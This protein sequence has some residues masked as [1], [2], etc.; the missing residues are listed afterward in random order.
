[1]GSGIFIAAAL[2]DDW[3]QSICNHLGQES[4]Q[5]RKSN[6]QR[7]SFLSASHGRVQVGRPRSESWEQDRKEKGMREVGQS[8]RSTVANIMEIEP[9]SIWK[10]GTCMRFFHFHIL[11]LA[12][13]ETL[14]S[15]SN[16]VTTDPTMG[17]FFHK[18]LFLP[19][20]T[21]YCLIQL[22]LAKWPAS[23]QYQA[24]LLLDFQLHPFPIQ[25]RHAQKATRH[26][27]N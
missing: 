25:T 10:S 21:L 2:T 17:S 11:Q 22:V 15:S 4:T 23:L 24:S 14:P 27:V 20:L 16:I 3:L 18:P 12:T 19:C 9:N 8:L 7:S 13:T 1:M 6:P 5:K 26:V